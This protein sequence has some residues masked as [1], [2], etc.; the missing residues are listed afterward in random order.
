M[1]LREIAPEVYARDVLPLTAPLWAGRRTFD[2]Y[3]EQTLE[4]ARSAY[5]RRHYRTIGLFDGATLVASFKRYERSI[6]DGG[7]QLPAIGFGAV[8]TPAEFRGRGYASVMLA[9][10]LDRARSA[11]YELAYLFSD[12]RPQFYMPLGFVELPSRD[13]TLRAGALPA[14]RVRPAALAPEDWT[15]VRRCFASCERARCAGFA[16]SQSVWGWISMR[17]KHGSERSAGHEFNL[18]VRRGRGVRAYVLGARVPERDAYVVDEYGHADEDSA[19][20]PALLRAA[21]GDLRRII[22]WLP[23]AGLRALLPTGT[24]RKRKRSI[25]MMVP[26]RPEGRRLVDRIAAER[27]GDFCWATEHI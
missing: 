25:F 19:L 1:R 20:I 23:P 24:T 13:L 10:E 2:V 8:Y 18:V 15:G 4:T 17:I 9:T 26:L 11:G 3:V 7:R 5:G 6:R 12:I 27:S 22:G 14:Q 21:A 16:R